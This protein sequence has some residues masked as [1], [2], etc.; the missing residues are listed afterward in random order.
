MK[1]CSP[2]GQKS[3]RKEKETLAALRVTQHAP[4]PVCSHTEPWGWW[5]YCFCSPGYAASAAQSSWICWP[6][7]APDACIQGF[8]PVLSAIAK[9][10]HTW[11]WIPCEFERSLFKG[12][13][14]SYHDSTTRYFCSCISCKKPPMHLPAGT[15]GTFHKKPL[16]RQRSHEVGR[17][18]RL[19]LRERDDAGKTWSLLFQRDFSKAFSL[20]LLWATVTT[21]AKVISNSSWACKEMFCFLLAVH[22]EVPEPGTEPVPEQWPELLQHKVRSLSCCTARDL[23]REVFWEKPLKMK[24]KLAWALGPRC[25]IGQ[26]K[27]RCRSELSR[28]DGKGPFTSCPR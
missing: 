18:E 21:D 9:K 26:H 10:N 2:D 22:V 3:I 11:T 12:H 6:S 25:S 8:S 27:S 4:G 13:Y 24:T 14:G 5:A 17:Q 16:R 23:Q 20:F 1:F 15:M 19:S 28:G 7:S